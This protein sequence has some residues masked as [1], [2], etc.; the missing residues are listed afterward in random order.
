MFYDHLDRLKSQFHLYAQ[1]SPAEEEHA[2][3]M[4]FDSLTINTFGGHTASAQ[5]K[6][7]GIASKLHLSHKAGYP[8]PMSLAPE[9]C[10]HVDRE[11]WDDRRVEHRYE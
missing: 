11:C 10:R 8:H 9:N 3:A 4:E 7:M 5:L 2:H 1:F 6:R